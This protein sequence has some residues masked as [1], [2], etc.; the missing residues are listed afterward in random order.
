MASAGTP[1]QHLAT[2]PSTKDP[3]FILVY[4]THYALALAPA[5]TVP[6]SHAL[7]WPQ[8]RGGGG[9]VATARAYMRGARRWAEGPPRGAEFADARAGD[10]RGQRGAV[11]SDGGAARRARCL[12]QAG[13][14]FDQAPHSASIRCMRVHRRRGPY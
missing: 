8:V 5:L 7:I 12:P 6:S 13:I 9:R 11:V 2:E 4:S 1:F 10:A 3:P 14:R